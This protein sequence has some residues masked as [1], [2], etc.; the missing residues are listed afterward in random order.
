MDLTVYLDLVFLLNFAVDYLL[1]LGTNRISGFAGGWISGILAAALGGI[2]GAACLLPGFR[3]LGNGFWR[4]VFLVLMGGIAFGWNRSALRRIPVFVILSMAL[5]GLA[6]GIHMGAMEAMCIGGGA[7]WLLC[8]GAFSGGPQNQEYLPAELTLG[9]KTVKL[10]ALRDTGN[11]LRDP[12]TGEQILVCGADVGET[13]L[14]IPKSEFKN[15]VDAVGKVPGLRLIPYHAVGNPNGMML[16]IRL[17]KAVIGNVER[18]PLVA[19]APDEIGKGHVY[20]ML[21]GGII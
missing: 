21:T 13:L 9:E 12:L 11:T 3:F 6:S 18:K 7:L 5:G 19:F 4:I 8:K 20:R 14:G 17:S 15:P 10:L 2:Y 16:V 1:L